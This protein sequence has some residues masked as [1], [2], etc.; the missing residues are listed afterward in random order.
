MRL[1][2]RVLLAVLWMGMICGVTGAF[3]GNRADASECRVGFEKSHHAPPAIES[4]PVSAATSSAD[5]WIAAPV[6][7]VALRTSLGTRVALP[8]ASRA[9]TLAS[10]TALDQR[11]PPRYLLA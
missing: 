5:E 4:A 11:P 3:S 1:A 6:I 2:G 7:G 8:R 10:E 9:I